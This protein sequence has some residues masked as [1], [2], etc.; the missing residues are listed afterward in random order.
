MASLEDTFRMMKGD[1][2]VN[3][4]KLSVS[5]T[6][7]VETKAMMMK[8]CDGKPPGKVTSEFLDSDFCK[9]DNNILGY[10]LN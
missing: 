1:E 2:P 3:T 10:F 8:S 6:T 7:H 4:D 9:F 5:E